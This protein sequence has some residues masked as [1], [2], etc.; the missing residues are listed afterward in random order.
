MRVG[1]VVP[2][3]VFDK[4]T[5]V[6]GCIATTIFVGVSFFTTT[7]CDVCDLS[8]VGC[9]FLDWLIIAAKICSME[10]VAMNAALKDDIAAHTWHSEIPNATT[11][12]SNKTVAKWLKRSVQNYPQQLSDF[13][14]ANTS[15][16]INISIW[17]LGQDANQFRNFRNHEVEVKFNSNKFQW[18][19]DLSLNLN[20]F[21]YAD[22][23][24]DPAISQCIW[25]RHGPS[26]LF[27]VR[28]MV[29][30]V[31]FWVVVV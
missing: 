16:K 6:W 29:V 21:R 1:S 10:C 17:S 5:S 31:F 11:I 13:E 8:L 26:I 24:L 22:L 7:F 25:V 12:K 15:N 30:D 20:H 23:D 4:L 14:E 2:L 27:D 28:V 19:H 18:N 3:T 9:W